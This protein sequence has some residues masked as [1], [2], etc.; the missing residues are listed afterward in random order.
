M[1][2]RLV[3]SGTR[4]RVREVKKEAIGRGMTTSEWLIW[5]SNFYWAVRTND[6]EYQDRLYKILKSKMEK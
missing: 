6:R 2:V 5:N 1:K 4:Q 3:I